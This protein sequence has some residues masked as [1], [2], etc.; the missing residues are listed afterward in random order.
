MEYKIDASS[1]KA[2]RYI[3][4]L[5]PSLMDQLKLNRSKKLLH[6]IVDKDLNEHGITMD[7][8]PVTGCYLMVLRG[9]RNLTE[10]GMTLAHELVHVKQMASGVLKHSSDGDTFWCGKKYGQTTRYIDCP[11]EIQAYSK[12]E[13]LFRRAIEE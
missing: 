2:K 7:F 9:T 6:I 3:G 1:T 10:L 13:L 11:W 12:Q 5:L 4:A 8:T